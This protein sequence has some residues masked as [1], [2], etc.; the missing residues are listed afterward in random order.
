MPYKD[1]EKAR[2]YHRKYSKK[3][4]LLQKRRREYQ[5][6][7]QELK[8]GLSCSICGENHPATLDFHHNDPTEK[9]LAVGTMV[10]NRLSK[11]RILK[12]IEKCSVLCANCHR[13]Q[14]WGSSSG[15][16]PDCTGEA[17]GV[18]PASPSYSGVA[19]LVGSWPHKPE[20]VG[21][22][23]TPATTYSRAPVAQLEEPP[24]CNRRV[25]CLNQGGG[26]R[27]RSVTVNTSVL[28]AD[29]QGSN[30]CGASI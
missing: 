3:H 30:P 18:N 12:E 22:S 13:K 26:S 9:D 24:I 6:W 20:A 5:Q 17:A 19:Q 10:A 27:P 14:H 15:R 4:C 8:Q 25:P 21:S 1:R 7:F 29:F 23:P 28:Q 11:R 16:A 2:E